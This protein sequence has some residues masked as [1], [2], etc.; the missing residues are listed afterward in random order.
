MESL[1]LA[2]G[3]GDS[4]STISSKSSY[5]RDQRDNRKRAEQ[6]DIM[7][8][9]SSRT[10]G[11]WDLPNLDLTGDSW[12]I[13]I[14]SDSRGTKQS[15]VPVLLI[16]LTP[17][18]HRPITDPHHLRCFPPLQPPSHRLQNFLYLHHPLC[19]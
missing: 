18:P 5:R 3:S 14:K 12:L 19:F 6:R 9:S 2:G 17:T 10:P 11:V 15:V 16:T 13:Q 7:I 1:R 4:V 8:W